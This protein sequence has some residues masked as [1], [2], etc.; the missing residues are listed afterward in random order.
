[1]RLYLSLIGVLLLAAWIS[2]SRGHTSQEPLPPP[3]R[4]GAAKP[5]KF[6]LQGAGSCASMACHN[7]DATTGYQGREYKIALERDFNQPVPCVKDKHAQAYAV[8]FNDRSQRMVRHLQRLPADAIVHPEQVDLC[9]RCH[10]QP[11]YKQQPALWMR[12]EGVSCEACHGAA[13]RWLATHFR[14]EF[15][16]LPVEVRENEYGM[17]DTRSVA[18]RVRVCVDCH[19]GSPG[20]EVDHDLIAAGHPRLSFEFSRFHHTFHKHWDYAKDKDPARNDP[21]RE[22]RGRKDFEARA[23]ALG[24][25][26]SAEASLRL[27]AHRAETNKAWPELAE[28][29]CYAC[30]HDL[31]AKSQRQQNYVKGS[32]GKLTWNAWYYAL[33]PDALEALGAQQPPAFREQLRQVQVDLESLQRDRKKTSKLARDAADQLRTVLQS[34]LSATAPMPADE[35]FSRILVGADA[36]ALQTWD[37]AAQVHAALSALGNARHEMGRPSPALTD[38]ARALRFPS[39][40]DSPQLYDRA[41]VEKAIESLKKANR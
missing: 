19:I 32:A 22:P 10:V 29:N 12:A 14:P 30:H 37:H 35:S 28:Y 26:V 9:L 3:V 8:L 24:Q 40:Y 21:S 34:E 31:E 18:G 5:S 13:E 39:G 4:S 41:Q 25:V 6:A 17:Y 36:R 1:M 15:K 2:V 20:A 7:A 16:R 23:W 33:L 38:L 27:L 11:D